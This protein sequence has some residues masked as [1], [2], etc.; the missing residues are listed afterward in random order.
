MLA[1]CIPVSGKKYFIKGINEKFYN[2]YR[3]GAKVFAK[4]EFRD[5][6]MPT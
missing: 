3:N 6:R 4:T 2:K 5:L 1:F